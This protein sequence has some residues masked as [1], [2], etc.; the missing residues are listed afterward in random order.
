MINFT[1]GWLQR[2]AR[3]LSGKRVTP[4]LPDDR[5]VLLPESDALEPDAEVDADRQPAVPLGLFI[6]YQNAK[7]ELSQRRITVRQLTGEPPQLMLAYCHERRAIRSF[8]FDRIIEA[9]DPDTGELFAPA[10]L[11]QLVTEG[12]ARPVDPA[13]RRIVNILV[14]I[15]KCDGHAHAA[16][17]SVIEEHLTSWTLR[18][19]GDDEDLE[20]ALNL[21]RHVAP[22]ADDFLAGMRS[23]AS[24]REAGA[25]GRFLA[26]AIGAVVDADG[27]MHPE[28]FE[29]LVE[30]R[31]FLNIMANRAGN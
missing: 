6:A 15:M 4:K 18:N 24:S 8:R 31:D 10:A 28:E 16:E 29:W 14:F 21:A 13:T 23:F 19:G 30:T 12:G 17:W 20:A 25:F 22:D 11:L 3:Q 26:R 1:D 5:K 27:V 9:M 2:L 7:G